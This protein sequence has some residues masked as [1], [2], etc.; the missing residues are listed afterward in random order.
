M[1]RVSVEQIFSLVF[2]HLSLLCAPWWSKYQHI[3]NVFLGIKALGGK[4]YCVGCYEIKIGQNNHTYIFSSGVI[5]KHSFL[6]QLSFSLNRGCR[7][8]LTNFEWGCF[9][10]SV[11]L[12]AETSCT[13]HSALG[14]T[15]RDWVF[16]RRIWKRSATVCETSAALRSGGKGG[17][18]SGVWSCI[19][20][21]VLTFCDYDSSLLMVQHALKFTRL[22]L[23]NETKLSKTFN[24][25]HAKCSFCKSPVGYYPMRVSF[26]TRIELFMRM[27]C[28][29]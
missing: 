22:F 23:P 26:Y 9:F 12:W 29:K 11:L 18:T 13:T 19:V 4:N 10:R 27:L 24:G 28:G 25:K 7:A 14:R 15:S 1:G 8:V 17:F 2:Q 3:H 5:K 16:R 20:A 21:L 6:R